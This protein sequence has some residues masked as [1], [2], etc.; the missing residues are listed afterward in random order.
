MGYYSD[1]IIKRRRLTDVIESVFAGH[2][3]VI[4]FKKKRY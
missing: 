3:E 2:I 4:V 1:T